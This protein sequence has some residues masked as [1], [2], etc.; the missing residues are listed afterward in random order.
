MSPEDR[1]L[2]L[3]TT[4]ADFTSLLLEMAPKYQEYKGKCVFA[5]TRCG[6]ATGTFHA[7][8]YV[9]SYYDSCY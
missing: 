5:A 3:T 7:S 6:E 9:T 4:C 1:Q 8:A 2:L